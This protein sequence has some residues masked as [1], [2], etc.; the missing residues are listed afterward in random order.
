M[1]CGMTWRYLEDMSRDRLCAEIVPAST[2][3]RCK[4]SL[5]TVRNCLSKIFYK[6]NEFSFFIRVLNGRE[7]ET[8]AG[9]L[10]VTVVQFRIRKRH[11]RPHRSW[12]NYSAKFLGAEGEIKTEGVEETMAE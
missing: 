12:N 10:T 3:A 1:K 6:A 5:A 2:T 9:E 7:E 4:S 8:K 11:K